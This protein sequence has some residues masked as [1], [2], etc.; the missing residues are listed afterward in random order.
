MFDRLMLLSA[1]RVVYFGNIPNAYDV[2][3]KAGFPVPANANPSDFFLMT[4]NRDFQDVQ[5][6]LKATEGPDDVEGSS[7]YIGAHVTVEDNI[8]MIIS[9]YESSEPYKTMHDMM[10]TLVADPQ[11]P[12]VENEK[13]HP[14]HTT[15]VLTE[16]TFKNMFRHAGFFWLR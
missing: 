11:D 7:K 9:V 10:E 12:F 15:A 14:V 13:R 8:N 4:I 5:S 2:F 1:G 3:A 6:E 16:R